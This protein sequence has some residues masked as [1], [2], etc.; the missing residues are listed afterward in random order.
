MIA[1][2]T[3]TVAAY[4]PVVGA[5]NVPRNTVLSVICNTPVLRGTGQLTLL[6][7][8][9]AVVE[10]FDVAT[11]VRITVSENVILVRPT[12]GLRFNFRYRLDIPDGAFTNA[13]LEPFTQL[14]DYRFSTAVQSVAVVAWDPAFL[15]TD[16]PS[17]A[18]IRLTF[19][20]AVQPASGIIELLAAPHDV[21]E[22]FSVAHSPR[23]SF[24]GS[25]VTITPTSQLQPN[26]L[27][28]LNIPRGA[29]C[30]FAGVPYAGT[31]SY[32]FSTSHVLG[33]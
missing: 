2:R 21:I 33:A 28:F 6:T 15:A 17:E 11:S 7:D 5:T 3:P 14:A 31:N 20:T 24:A 18:V 10:R 19:N 12:G 9:G 16:V 1:E 22:S 27:Y 29:V 25:V 23:V 32:S 13:T 4:D 8:A 26:R 30:D